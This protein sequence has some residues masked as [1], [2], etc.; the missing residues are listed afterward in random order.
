MIFSLGFKKK[1][2]HPCA[3]GWH[4]KLD[5]YIRSGSI[6]YGVLMDCTKA[7]DTVQHSKLFRKKLDANVPSILVRLLIHIYRRQ[8]AEVRWSVHYQ[9]WSQTRGHIVSNPV[10][11]L[12]E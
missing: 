2:A 6:V 12:H 4:L 5:N 11:L 3:L 9:K 7:F 1:T 10:L 8:T